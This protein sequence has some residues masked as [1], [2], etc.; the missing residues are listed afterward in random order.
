MVQDIKSKLVMFID[1]VVLG[2]I[3]GDGLIQIGDVSAL[4]NHYRNN[5]ILTGVYLE[6]GLLTGNDSVLIGDVSKL[7]NF[8]KGNTNL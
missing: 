5:K 2:D 7:Y 1:V 8:Y 4:Y 6:A 3:T